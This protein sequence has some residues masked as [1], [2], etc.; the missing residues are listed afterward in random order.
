[1]Q[2]PWTG[3][4][5]REANSNIVSSSS[6]IYHVTLNWI[7]VVIFGT[8]CTANHG[9]HMLIR[10]RQMNRFCSTENNLFLLHEDGKDAIGQVERGVGGQ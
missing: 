1:M 7:C 2:E 10:L 4:I 9:E 3:I 5:S 6:N 8:V